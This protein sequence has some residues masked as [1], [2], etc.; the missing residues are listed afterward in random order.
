M[1]SHINNIINRKIQPVYYVFPPTEPPVFT[2]T[3]QNITVDE[4]NQITLNCHASGK[5]KPS[6]L[7]KKDGDDLP[8]VVNNK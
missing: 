7:W 2:V 1:I 6:I 8:H 3:P 5:P 4:G